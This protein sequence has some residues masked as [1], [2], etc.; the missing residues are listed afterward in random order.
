MSWNPSTGGNGSSIAYNIYRCTGAGCTATQYIDWG[1]PTSYSS[2]GLTCNTTYGY[3]VRAYDGRPSS[4]NYSLPAYATTFA[5]ALTVTTTSPAT[6]IAST[7]VTVGGNVT[8]N[9]GASITAHGICLGTN[10]TP[11]GCQNDGV[12]TTGIF[13]QNRTGLNPSTLYYYRAYAT[14]SVGTSY[15][16]DVT[17]TT[18]ANIIAPTGTL[19]G[20]DCTIA[21]NASTCTTSL[22][23]NVTNP[24]S[25]AQTN[26][27]KPTNVEVISSVTINNTF[28]K[29]V[30]GIVVGYPSTTFYLNH[31]SATLTN[32]GTTINATCVSGTG[33]DSTNTKCASYTIT[34]NGNGNT[35]GSTAIQTIASG[36]TAALR[37]NGFTKS[38]HTFA[39]WATTANGS[40]AYADQA[41]YIMESS[42]V[43][44]YAQWTAASVTSGTLTGSNCIITTTASTCPTSLT[45]NVTNPVAGA[46]TNVT[47]PTNVQVISNATINN[48]FPKTVTG[49]V[50]DYPS[51]TFYLNHNG[52]TLTNP[53]TTITASCDTA[54]NYVWD[55]GNLRCKLSG[56]GSPGIDLTASAP[57]QNTATKNVAQTFTSTIS[58]IGTL[59]TGDTFRNSMQVAESENGGSPGYPLY[60]S[61]PLTLPVLGPGETN[62]VTATYTFPI[63]KKYSVRFCADNNINMMGLIDEGTNEGNNCSAWVNVTVSDPGP[64]VDGQCSATH[65]FCTTGTNPAGNFTGGTNVDGAT[66]WTWSCNG[67]GGGTNATCSEQ[68]VPINGVC[69]TTHYNCTSGSSINNVDGATSW[70][71]SCTGADGGGD[72]SCSQSK[73]KKPIFKED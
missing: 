62:T 61:S 56:G 9:G 67:S 49:I 66:S 70:T 43:T 45:L 24:V 46:Q 65:Y 7:S 8:S 16:S 10:P 12:F 22:T 55:G 1:Y 48:T 37:A 52:G 20:S 13:T 32:P 3:R 64:L 29:T 25:G 18:T 40:I 51:T 17:F 5:C 39:G 35:G 26:V 44:L 28:P 6:N 15:G 11:L 23:L 30:S 2:T 47:K 31:N 69:S 53:G 54:N 63:T 21:A 36:A 38:G 72:I 41:N 14:N 4:S 19:T 34:F 60:A 73:T 33:W 27:T 68:K 58:N 57:T 59:S 42:N 71:W 50:V